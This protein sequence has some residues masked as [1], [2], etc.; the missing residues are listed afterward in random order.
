MAE[1]ALHRPIGSQCGQSE[2]VQVL[3]VVFGEVPQLGHRLHQARLPAARRRLGRGAVLVELAEVGRAQG[4]GQ[5]ERTPAQIDVDA[6]ARGNERQAELLAIELLSGR[7]AAAP[8]QHLQ[9]QAAAA[10]E[11]AVRAESDEAAGWPPVLQAVIQIDVQATEVE[12]QRIEDLLVVAELATR[13]LAGQQGL[14]QRSL[15]AGEQDL[16]CVC[17]CCV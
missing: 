11:E 5:A 4:S 12:A 1:D 14:L 6:L 3:L 13:Q 17:V 8:V 2:P 16:V 7:T 10:A 9:R 15:A